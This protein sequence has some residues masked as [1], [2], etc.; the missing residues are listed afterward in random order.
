[1]ELRFD[2]DGLPAVFRRDDWTGA[3][4][5]DV[6]GQVRSLESPR[7]LSTHFSFK[8]CRIWHERIG[9]HAV[10]IEKV[11]PLLFAGFRAQAFTVAIDGRKVAE[12]SGK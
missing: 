11:R 10:E 3:V 8:R 7:K 6:A 2:V 1:M 9:G 12:A 4:E 5:L